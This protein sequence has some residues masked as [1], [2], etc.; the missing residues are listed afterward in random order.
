[1]PLSKYI[2]TKCRIDLT[3]INMANSSICKNCYNIYMSEYRENNKEKIREYHREYM[4][5]QRWLNGGPDNH[6]L[7]GD[8]INVKL[9]SCGGVLH[10]G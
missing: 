10:V 8:H 1:M 4:R 7:I 5:L 9:K 2:C 3:P 6:H